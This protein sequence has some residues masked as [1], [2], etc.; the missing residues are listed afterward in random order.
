M[1]PHAARASVR[2]LLF[3]T[4]LASTAGTAFSAGQAAAPINSSQIKE[5]VQRILGDERDLRR[6][7]DSVEGSEVTLRGRVPTLWAKSEAIRK[8]LDVDGVE[9]V[10]SELEIPAV[11]DDSD[12]IEEIA[13]A[14]YGYVHYTVWDYIDGTVNR[15]VVTLEGSVTPGIDKAGDLFER[16]A[17]IPGVQDVHSTIETQSASSF[18]ADI[19]SA[20]ARRIFGSIE[21]AEYANRPNPPFHLIVDDS[22]VRLTGVVRSEVEKARLGQIVRSTIG[23]ISVVNDLQTGQ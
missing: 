3:S 5:D 16:V 21:F 13:K 20:L 19:R 4:V 7:E 2:I 18:D 14:V 11:E 23:V 10:A 8:T 15:G 17:K 22:T 12:L 6:I 1:R 9:T